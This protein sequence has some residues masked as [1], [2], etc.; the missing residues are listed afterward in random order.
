[1]FTA[2]C[3]KCALLKGIINL[4]KDA[5]EKR[6]I[7]LSSHGKTVEQLVVLSKEINSLTTVQSSTTNI[8]SK[9][10]RIMSYAFVINVYIIDK[11]ANATTKIE[12]PHFS[13]NI[14]SEQ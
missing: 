12:M 14:F 10:Q 1:M 11:A 3:E 5:C 4:F 9:G 2:L 8:A 6:I 7:L 13:K